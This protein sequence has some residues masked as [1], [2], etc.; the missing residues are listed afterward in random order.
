MMMCSAVSAWREVQAS[1]YERYVR[2]LGVDGMYL[3]QFGFANS[4]KDCWSSEH[5][6]TVPGS[7]MLGERGMTRLVRTRMEAARPGVALYSE[8][9][10]CDVN[11]QYQDGSF[12][13][14]MSQLRRYRPLAPLHAPRFAIPS[15]KTFEILVCDHP[16]GSWSEGVKWT[17]FNGEGI[18]LEGP[19]TTWFEPRTR[20]AVRRCHALLRRYRDAFCSDAPVP[21][22]PTKTPGVLGNR[23]PGREATVLTLYNARHRAVVARVPFTCF[24]D[25]PDSRAASR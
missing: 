6:H 18:W 12:S 4:G 13:Y 23:F 2:E 10:P 17:F 15:F 25:T 9:V 7:T 8:E 24:G 1:T 3:D 11:S 16:M 19:A 21:L 20:T 14:H 22:V 5:G